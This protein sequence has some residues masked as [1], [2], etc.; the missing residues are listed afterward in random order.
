M[1]VLV[2][3]IGLGMCVS[4]SPSYAQ[5][6]DGLQ[7]TVAPYMV[8]PWMTG[9]VGLRGRDVSVDS[10]PKDIFENLE[11]GIMGYF[12]VRKAGWAFAFD[13]LYM[14]LK[15]EA[16]L[17]TALGPAGAEL[18]I[19]QGA[20]ELTGARTLAPWADLVFGVR[21]NRIDGS[22]RTLLT[23][24]ERENT[25]TWVDPVIGTQLV[26][27]DTGRWRVALRA[28]VGGFG[29]G[30]D[31]AWQLF[32]S[33]GFDVVDWFGLTGGYRA[34]STNYHTG[35]GTDAFRYDMTT[36]GPFMGAAFRF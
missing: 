27:P 23:Q 18:T 29:A 19:S 9:E 15:K 5:S 8:A 32:P 25:Q 28:D 34:L 10:G 6:S 2:T 11:V 16:T 13:G 14:N 7:F 33:V 3:I 24:I 21:I 4:V 30:S 31:F 17:D 22:F 12:E 1:R 26:V 36:H 35:E 20:Y